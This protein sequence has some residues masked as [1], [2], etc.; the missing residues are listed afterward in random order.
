MGTR[1]VPRAAEELRLLGRFSLGWCGVTPIR[2]RVGLV[3]ALQLLGGGCACEGD[4]TQLDAATNADAPAIDAPLVI[5]W[6]IGPPRDTGERW[7]WGLADTGICP[8]HGTCQS[9]EDCAY[10]GLAVGPP[11]TYVSS[12]CQ[13]FNCTLGVVDCTTADGVTSCQCG[14]TLGC[15][16]GQICVSDS[17]GGPTRCVEAC[18]GR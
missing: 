12:S 13:G 6:D 5:D 8:I 2:R 11:G 1:A 17:P 14:P 16:Y 7:D 4:R 3:I 9:D 10:W 18:Q 15:T